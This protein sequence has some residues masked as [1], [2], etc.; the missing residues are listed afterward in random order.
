LSLQNWSMPSFW[1]LRET[2]D[3]LHLRASTK[4]WIRQLMS[5][6]DN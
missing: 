6:W 2:V 5:S 4:K 3:T 1:F